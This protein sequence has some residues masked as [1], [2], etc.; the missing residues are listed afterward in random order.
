MEE[1]SP[2]QN[3]M[4]LLSN[5]FIMVQPKDITLFTITKS[6]RFEF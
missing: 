3:T 2:D 4:T 5:N 1:D 6:A